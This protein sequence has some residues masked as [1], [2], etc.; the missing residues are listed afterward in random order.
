M[1]LISLFTIF[2]IGCGNDEAYNN[3]IQKGLDYIA[4]EEYQKAESA[5]ELALDEKKEDVKASALLKQ[6]INY[7]EAL[8]AF[9]K[10][11][12]TVVKEKAEIVIKEKE[13]S[14][15]LIK[16]ADA[17]LLSVETL[18][19][20]L[21]AFNEQWENALEQFKEKEYKDA[22]KIIEALLNSDLEHPFF[23]GI[24]KQAEEVQKDIKFALKKEKAEEERVAK[25]KEKATKERVE[26]EKIAKEKAEKEAIERAAVEKAK[27][28]AE[29]N[30][31]TGEK[32]YQ[33]AK[34]KY[35][36]GDTGY[37]YDNEV[38]YEAGKAYF[39]VYLYS[40]V[41]RE[42]GGLGNLFY[43]QVFEDGTIVE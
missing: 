14:D 34:N 25:V 12:F 6:I 7:Q 32:A 19:E 38:S 4:S 15:A 13:G 17:I 1:F 39:N 42:E 40:N 35:G 8:I 41:L 27:K 26:K 5:F 18:E 43:V 24:K 16:K 28:E 29:E 11:D 30:V 9:E 36:G 20:E 10:T 2:I 3:A 37:T 23:H 22:N 33:I 31:F 21:I